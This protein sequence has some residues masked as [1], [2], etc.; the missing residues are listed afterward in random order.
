MKKFFS[1]VMLLLTFSSNFFYFSFADET[2]VETTINW[3]NDSSVISENLSEEIDN[4]SLDQTN[5]NQNL[6][7]NDVDNVCLSWDLS[8]EN[9]NVESES[10]YSC[11]NCPDIIDDCDHDDEFCRFCFLDCDDE[12]TDSWWDLGDDENNDSNENEDILPNLI[13]SEVFFDGTKEWIEIY[14]AWDNFE[15]YIDLNINTKDI[16][17]DDFEILSWEIIVIANN[18]VDFISN[19]QLQFFEKNISIT[20]TKE[21]NI[22]IYSE[23]F[24]TIDSFHVDESDVKSVDKK[25]NISRIIRR[26]TCNNY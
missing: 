23:D 21:I 24:D 25:K 20:D 5:L 8:N 18:S 4:S 16:E 3:N 17:I 19:I 2:V 22:V 26:C 10:E 14:N 15:W 13:I 7:I 6:D 1:V 9:V 11:D 12:W